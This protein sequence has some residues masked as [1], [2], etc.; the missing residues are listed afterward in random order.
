MRCYFSIIYKLTKKLNSLT[1]LSL[2]TR[3]TKAGLE[4]V[5]VQ[6]GLDT[7]LSTLSELESALG[8]GGGS[9]GASSSPAEDLEDGQ[10]PSAIST[11][12]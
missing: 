2:G 9:S 11:K 6:W 7:G 10:K 4:L 1:M 5:M 3:I 8:L 12:Q